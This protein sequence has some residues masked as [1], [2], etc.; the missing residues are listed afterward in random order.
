MEELGCA[1]FNMMRAGSSLQDHICGASRAGFFKTPRKEARVN[2]NNQTPLEG[3]KPEHQSKQYHGERQE[4]PY[5][6][7]KPLGSGAR[8]LPASESKVERRYLEDPKRSYELKAPIQRDGLAEDMLERINNTEVTVKL[9]DLFGMSK[10]LREGEKLRLTRIRQPL[11]EE[12][13]EREAV[14]VVEVEQQE[15]ADLARQDSQLMS[16]TSAF[17]TYEGP[18]T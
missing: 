3:D 17:A 7:I 6:F 14:E 12:P 15:M 1:V 2:S 8:T 4:L 5:R 9:K 18:P 13:K 16:S 10:D 11:K